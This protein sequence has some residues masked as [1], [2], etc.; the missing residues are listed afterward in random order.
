MR[1]R[2]SDDKYGRWLGTLGVDV[3]LPGASGTA[4]SGG[5]QGSFVNCLE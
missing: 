4:Y 5:P 1:S 3:G 2:I